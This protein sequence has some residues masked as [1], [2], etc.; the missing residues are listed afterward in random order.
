MLLCRV[1]VSI[2]VVFLMMRRPQISTRTD[3][4]FPYTT[5]FRSVD[6]DLGAHVPVR[7]RHRLGRRDR[8]HLGAAQGAER[9]AGG[10]ED[11]AVDA[12]RPVEVEHLEDGVVLRVDGQQ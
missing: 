4:L 6:G 2:L 10:G 11:E 8:G 7:V 3:T 5:L 1:F 12:L 9:A